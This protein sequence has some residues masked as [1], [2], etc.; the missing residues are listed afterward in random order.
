MLMLF[1]L[2]GISVGDVAFKDRIDA[3]NL[4]LHHV[5]EPKAHVG[6]QDNLGADAPAEAKTNVALQTTAITSSH[7]PSISV[8]I[9]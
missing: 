4:L 3:S 6:F 2:F 9:E 7:S 5:L 8:N 1:P